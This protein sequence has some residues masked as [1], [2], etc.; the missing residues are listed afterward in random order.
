MTGTPAARRRP[1]AAGA[2][3]AALTALALWFAALAA[4]QPAPALVV[5]DFDNQTPAGASSLPAEKLDYLRRALSE[6]LTVALLAVPGLQVVERQRLKDVLA[7]QKL[8]AGELADE[9]ARLRLGRIVGAGRM[10]F[11]GFFALGDAVQV[12]LRV[13]DS[14]TSQVWFSDEVTA[15]ADSAMERVQAMN[16][17]LIQRLGGGAEAARGYPAKVWQ[18]YDQALALSDAGRYEQAIEA[19]QRLLAQQSD[20]TP[21]ERQLVALLEKMRRR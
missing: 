3:R 14:A 11:G 7:E 17:H 1:P 21:A 13:V 12:N 10:V 16:R 8:S 15:D 4:A 2:G 6:N 5:W 18:A 9:D 19:L 20:F